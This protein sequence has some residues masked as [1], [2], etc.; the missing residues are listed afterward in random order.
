MPAAAALAVTSV[1]ADKN[2]QAYRVSLGG[3]LAAMAI[4][5]IAAGV[6]APTANIALFALSSLCVAA[7]IMELGVCPGTYLYIAVSLLTF[8]WPGI[9]LAWPFVIFFGPYPLIR[10]MVFKITT[11]SISALAL[12]LL[13]ANLAA[14]AAVFL[15]LRVQLAGLWDKMGSYIWLFAILLQIVLLLYDAGLQLLIRLYQQKF[16]KN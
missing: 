2:S 6:Y 12:R 16:K 5:A 15:F 3:L 14:A 8:A 13:F 11:N 1:V 9:A 4:I 7:A 10:Y